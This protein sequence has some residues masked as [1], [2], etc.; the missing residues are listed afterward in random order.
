MGDWLQLIQCVP[1]FSEGR[2]DETLSALAGAARSVPGVALVDFSA[3]PDHHRSVYTL[4]GP[5]EPTLEAIKKMAYLA[6]E[7]IDL[8]Q[9]QGVHPRIGALDVL[10]F[11]PYGETP[12]DVAVQLAHAAG[13]WLAETL[14]LPVFLYEAAAR[15]SHRVNLA[16]FRNMG[17]EK[18]SKLS[19]TGE[20]APDFGP[21]RLHPSAGAAAVGARNPL[22]AF[23]VELATSSVEVARKVAARV[24]EKGGG[25][26]GVKALGLPVEGRGCVQVSLNITRP[27]DVPLYRV[28]ELI[29][30]EA[31]RH[32]VSL[33]GSE[34]IGAIRLEELLEVARYYLGLHG[35]R[36]EQVL[37]LWA[38]ALPTERSDRDGEIE[39]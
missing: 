5:P 27:G 36:R 3:D 26:V 7:R 29:R 11:V 33:A 8:A 17:W 32:G 12:L 22:V 9:H 24:R 34:L 4:L 37:D 31:A 6:V 19:L 15:S 25:L 1:N 10:P 18:L 21:D 30:L 16:A 28:V 2:D 14:Q 35:L 13:E 38:A 39:R 20:W 23:N